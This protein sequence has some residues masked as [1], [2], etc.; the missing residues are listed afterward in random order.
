MVNVTDS[1]LLQQIK[2]DSQEAFTELHNR[3]HLLLFAYAFKLTGE[4]Q[5]AKDLVQEI[6]I[7]LWNK[8]ATV[9]VSVSI[10]AYLYSAVRYKFLKLVAH[11]KI[12][13]DYAVHFHKFMETAEVYADD[14]LLFKELI[15][16]VERLAD[17][18]PGKMGE[19][20]LMSKVENYSNEEIAEALQ[21][22]KKTVQNMLSE[23]KTII[24]AK[25]KG[26]YFHLLGLFW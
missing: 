19:A 11:N 5:A 13:A 16:E 4:E 18:L 7:S 15:T 20:F 8:R 24:R 23:A 22:S 14:T 6:F 9:Y 12:R 3:Y 2:Q 10:R 17:T 25:R 21:L 26:P 1:E